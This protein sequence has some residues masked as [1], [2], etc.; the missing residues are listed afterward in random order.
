M[1]ENA[2]TVFEHISYISTFLEIQ[3]LKNEVDNL[4]GPKQSSML[5]GLTQKDG[6]QDGGILIES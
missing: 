3:I 1:Q 6:K 4:V 2:H 5:I